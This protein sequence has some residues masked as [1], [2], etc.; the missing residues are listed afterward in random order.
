MGLAGATVAAASAPA[1]AQ[2]LETPSAIGDWRVSLEPVKTSYIGA[3]GE[4]VEPLLGQ[5]WS[6]LWTRGSSGA[7]LAAPAPAVAGSASSTSRG[8]GSP[9]A[10]GSTKSRPGLWQTVLPGGRLPSNLR[11]AYAGDLGWRA[12]LAY[13][14]SWLRL[15]N[16]HSPELVVSYLADGNALGAFAPTGIGIFSDPT[17]GSA[18]ANLTAIQEEIRLPLLALPSRAGEFTMLVGQGWMWE[19]GDS[20]GAVHSAFLDITARQKVSGI[21]PVFSLT[22]QWRPEA[23]A[24]SRLDIPGFAHF[25]GVDLS[26]TAMRTEY[27]WT[28]G[29]SLALVWR[30]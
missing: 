8:S 18:Q 30:M 27:M 4:Y 14:P 2:S 12:S 28:I 1:A 26:A 5:A 25:A 11:W 23:G 20:Y 6:R 9:P 29:A 17:R 10:G 3:Y 21:A 24:F 15:W 16:G 13:A 22:T 7:T 19:R